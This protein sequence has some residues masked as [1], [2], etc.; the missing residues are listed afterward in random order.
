MKMPDGARADGL[1]ASSVWSG[2][3]R[4]AGGASARKRASACATHVLKEPGSPQRT[5]LRET[6][7]PA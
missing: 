4:R 2:P 3:P 6:V 1:A 7:V 5:G